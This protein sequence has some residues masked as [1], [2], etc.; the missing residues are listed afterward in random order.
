M[1]QVSGVDYL[2]WRSIRLDW[3]LIELTACR[4]T[5]LLLLLL[6][7]RKLARRNN[8]LCYVTS[9]WS[10]LLFFVLAP[11]CT[12]AH[13]EAFSLF[14]KLPNRAR[15]QEN[16]KQI[17]AWRQARNTSLKLD[18]LWTAWTRRQTRQEAERQCKQTGTNWFSKAAIAKWI[19]S[20]LLI[21]VLLCSCIAFIDTIKLC[22]AGIMLVMTI[23]YFRS[24]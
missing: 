22:A 13:T 10:W 18:R 5:H 3:P 17:R 6:N 15:R 4:R 14:C 16:S 20:D 7:T 19:K 23:S 12:Y 21:T 8:Y 1:L 24:V 9:E 11:K 2:I